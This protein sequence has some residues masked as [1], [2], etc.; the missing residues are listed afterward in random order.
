MKNISS[1]DGTAIQHIFILAARNGV[2]VFLLL[3][4]SSFP[5]PYPQ[6]NPILINLANL[7]E[8]QANSLPQ[9]LN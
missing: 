6:V 5:P 7:G 9:E 4:L 2:D 8:G 3:R 1:T